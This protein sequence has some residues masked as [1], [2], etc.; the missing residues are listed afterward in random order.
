MKIPVEITALKEEKG[1]INQLRKLNFNTSNIFLETTK[2]VLV[3]C[4]ARSF[5]K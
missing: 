2:N 4:K 5:W 3:V 1:K